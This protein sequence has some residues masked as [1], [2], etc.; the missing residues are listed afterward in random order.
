M[1]K[2]SYLIILGLFGTVLLLTIISFWRLR[3]IGGSLGIEG[4]SEFEE[5][6]PKQLEEI[7]REI[8]EGTSVKVGSNK[9][10]SKEFISP[11]G[12]LK[13]EYPIDWS[14]IKDE[15]ILEQI[16]PKEEIEKYGLKNLFLAQKLQAG[17]YVQ[18]KVNEITLKEADNIETLIEG[19]K[20]S[21]LQQG[22]KM[23]IINLDIEEETAI[24][25]AKYEKPERLKIYSKEKI[26]IVAPERDNKKAFLVVLLSFGEDWEELQKEADEILHSVHLVN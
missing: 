23:E 11:D 8:R 2:K 24:F 12:K 18:L 5:V 1:S 14:E 17:K 20:E 10:G 16:L 22:W 3:E 13:M 26:L 4:L 9:V 6:E 25:E 15:K 19:M 21:N 7:I